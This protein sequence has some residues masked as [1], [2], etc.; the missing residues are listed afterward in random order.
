MEQPQEKH[1]ATHTYGAT[2]YFSIQKD[3]EE[4]EAVAEAEEDGAVEEE[5]VVE[6][7]DKILLSART[8]L[9]KIELGETR[10]ITFAIHA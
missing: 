10:L 8:S 7:E 4:G 6:E 1:I 9:E 2:L 5:E 3:V